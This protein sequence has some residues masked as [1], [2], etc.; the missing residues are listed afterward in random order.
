L[1]LA[2]LAVSQAEVWGFGQ[3]GGTAGAAALAAAGA[4]ALF[5]RSAQPLLVGV[6]ECALLWG[7][8]QVSTAHDVEPISATFIV[9][10]W[11]VWYALGSRGRSLQSWMGLALGL[12]YAVAITDPFRVDEYLAIALTTFV[13]PWLLGF[14]VSMR[15]EF[16]A[17]LQRTQSAD[18]RN[19]AARAADP[20]VLAALSPREAEVLEL[21]TAGRSNAEIAAELHVSL[22]TVKTHVVA[23]LRKL[24]VR[25]RT[26]A[27]VIALTKDH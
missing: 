7:A 2:L 18:A 22:A 9:A 21:M 27:V 14:L 16:A 1:A 10:F 17:E 13:V 26:Q 5:G 23:I 25:D 20:N 4:L 19:V 12:G 6:A 3:L 11:L 8:A 24:Q 15:A